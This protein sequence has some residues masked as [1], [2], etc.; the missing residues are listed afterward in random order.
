[1]RQFAK[2]QPSVVPRVGMGVALTTVVIGTLLVMACSNSTQPGS[3][4]A[5][6]AGA[7]DANQDSLPTSAAPVEK[8]DLIPAAPPSPAGTSIE[9]GRKALRR[10]SGPP[11]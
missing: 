6:S 11:R 2:A 5:P 9:E 10:W 4:V 1:M 7:E 8:V 3:T